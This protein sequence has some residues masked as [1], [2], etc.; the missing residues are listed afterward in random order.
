MALGLTILNGENKGKCFN[1]DEH[2]PSTIGRDASCSICLTDKLASKKHA[3]VSCVDGQ[4]Q[5][6]DLTAVNGT[7]VNGVRI[8][9]LL[10]NEGDNLTVGSSVFRVVRQA[11]GVDEDSIAS[12]AP[13]K[14]VIDVGGTSPEQSETGGTMPNVAECIQG[15]QAI[16]VRHSNDIVKESL[17]H[18]FRIIP[19][20]RIAVFNVAADGR[21]MQG[22]TVYRKAEGSPTNMSGSFALKVLEAKKA[23]LIEDA[24][25]LI[26]G[27]LDGSLG[28][29]G[30]H[31]I[32]GV[33]IIVQRK[34]IAVLLGDNLETPNILTD[35][36]L[37]M[38]QFAGKA[39]E[40][41]YHRD[42]V[43]KLDDMVRFL[44]VCDWC[45]RIRDDQGYW[46]ELESFVSERV[47]VR[48]SRSCCPQCA[49]KLIKS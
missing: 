11:V 3:T 7:F 12:I 30:V 1:V 48:L 14:Q 43:G 44:P 29:K 45:K 46:N 21:L 47:A 36:H 15:M 37:R 40:V 22:Y 39:I 27:T 23:L 8:S 6:D 26:S 4:L 42:A 18:I 49:G 38:M 10:L 9:S 32:I 2:K 34:T 13:N 25:E 16:V 24:D 17:K 20:S 19:F 5:I 31:S 41:L 33:P 35:E 28:F